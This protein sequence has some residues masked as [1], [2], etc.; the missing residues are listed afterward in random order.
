MARIQGVYALLRTAKSGE[1]YY[2]VRAANHQTLS[3]SETY[4]SPTKA[5]NAAVKMVGS[6]KVYERGDG[7]PHLVQVA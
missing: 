2:V 3:V 5:R 6:G 4:T 7:R 1:W